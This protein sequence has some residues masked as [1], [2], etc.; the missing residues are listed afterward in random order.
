MWRLFPKGGVFGWGPGPV[1]S[2]FQSPAS[3]IARAV[4]RS[5]NPRGYGILIKNERLPTLS[6]HGNSQKV[7]KPAMGSAR[8]SGS[9]HVYQ[10]LPVYQSGKE[11]PLWKLI[12]RLSAFME[13]M[14][15]SSGKVHTTRFLLADSFNF[16]RLLC[17]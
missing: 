9:A 11:E 7:S 6:I 5:D 15:N 16:A 12:R 13:S 1:T 3:C 2:R 10:S 4:A 14:L 8:I 17:F